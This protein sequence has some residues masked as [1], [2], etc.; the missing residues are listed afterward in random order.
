M[1]NS[2]TGDKAMQV[3]VTPNG[4]YIVTGDVPLAIQTITPNAAGESW[5]WEQGRRFEAQSQYALCRCGRSGHAP[6]CDGTHAKVG[7]DGTET[8][9]RAP[10]DAQKTTVTGPTINLGRRAPTLRGGP[11]LRRRPKLLGRDPADRP[12]RQAGDGHAPG[13]AVP[14]GPPG[15]P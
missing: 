8:A 10:Y 12:V 7:F 13:H 2:T 14:V 11:V 15:G 6:Y 4:P 5:E 1:D 3:L 9:S